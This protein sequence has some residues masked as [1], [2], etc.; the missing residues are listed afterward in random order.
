[1]TQS[2]HGT[3][4]SARSARFPKFRR[5]SSIG[6]AVRKEVVHT[7]ELVPATAV[8]LRAWACVQGQR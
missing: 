8:V 6:R 3:R 7:V 5:V 4:D 1:M 2:G